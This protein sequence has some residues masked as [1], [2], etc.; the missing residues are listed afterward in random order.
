MINVFI[1]VEMLCFTIA[2]SDLMD[3]IVDWMVV[4]WPE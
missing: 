4:L 3:V 1:L 2:F